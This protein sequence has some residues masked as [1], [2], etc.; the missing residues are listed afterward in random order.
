MIQRISQQQ[1]EAH[2]WVAAV[3]LRGTIDPDDNKPFIFPMSLYSAPTGGKE[4]VHPMTM[5][6]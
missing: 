5:R 2:L 3:L 6:P 4:T 1:L